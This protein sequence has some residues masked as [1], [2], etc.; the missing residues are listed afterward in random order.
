MC[1]VCIVI[2]LGGGGVVLGRQEVGAA[3]AIGEQVRAG[4]GVDEEVI[5]LAPADDLG[6]GAFEH[7]D[8][9]RLDTGLLDDD[10]RTR[11]RR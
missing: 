7:F 2:S 4:V 11:G 8:V 9:Q 10:C 5:L 3:L 1:V 6:A